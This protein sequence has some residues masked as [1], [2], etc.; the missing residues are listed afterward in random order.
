[1]LSDLRGSGSIEEDSDI[2]IMLYRPNVA[3]EMESKSKVS[4]AEI[5]IE[6]NRSG[7]E[8]IIK[9]DFIKE[10]TYFREKTINPEEE[11]KILSEISGGATQDERQEKEDN[12][13]ILNE[14]NRVD[15]NG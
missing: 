6:K 1:M 2:V 3:E 12:Q 14:L 8:A 9:V 13:K 11:K 15:L 4:E 10:F 5:L 7:P